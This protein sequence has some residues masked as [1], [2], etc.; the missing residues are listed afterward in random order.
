LKR[1]LEELE[2]ENWG[3]LSVASHLVTTCHSLR[4]VPIEELGIEDLR[5]LLGQAIGVVHLVPRALQIL[6]ANPLAEGD[7]YP[8]D[9]LCSVLRLDSLVWKQHP[10]WLKHLK[11]IVRRIENPPKEIRRECDIFLSQQA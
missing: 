6:D 3:E 11:D 10:D 2:G 5:I 1:T 8:G 7:F 9:L 4:R